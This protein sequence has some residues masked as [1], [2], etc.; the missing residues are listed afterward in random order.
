M[1]VSEKSASDLLEESF[2]LLYVNLTRTSHFVN[3]F[4]IVFEEVTGGCR[5]LRN[6]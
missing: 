1:F 6:D 3:L 4:W 5:E 2:L